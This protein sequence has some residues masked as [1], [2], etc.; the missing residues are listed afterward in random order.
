MT[1]K[2]AKDVAQQRM[3]QAFGAL[4][5]Q[6]DAAIDLSQAALLIASVEYPELDAT[7]YLALLDEYAWRVKSLLTLSET[8]PLRVIEALNQVLFV[9]ERFCG[10]KDDY[11]SPENS[12]FN[13][14]LDTH[15]GIPITLS[16]LYSE[17]ARRAGI[18]LD[19]IGFPFHFMVRYPLPEQNIYIDPYEG[20]IV[21]TEQDCEERLR[22]FSQHRQSLRT[23]WFEP[24]SHRHWLIRMLNNLK[25][26]YINQDDFVRSLSICDFLI[27]LQPASAIERR[28]RGLIYLQLKRYARSIKD[29]TA[30]TELAPQASDHDEILDYVKMA[31]QM[32]AM[33]N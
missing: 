4:I 9:E 19:G 5:K 16:L 11:Y 14:V 18:Q 17:V 15:T 1:D 30:Y 28:D 2:F 29:L 23:H 24:F 6:D 10:N 7:Y 8:E 22:Q 20:G 25:K 3:Y 27:L 26:I 13:R 31:H 33:L 21:V 12:Y 32:L